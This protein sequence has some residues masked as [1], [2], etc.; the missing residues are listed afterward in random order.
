MGGATINMYRD[1]KNGYIFSQS[2]MTTLSSG[3]STFNNMFPSQMIP[4][5]TVALPMNYS[6]NNNNKILLQAGL[7]S[8]LIDANSTGAKSTH[9]GLVYPLKNP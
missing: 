5:I 1:E 4:N 2:T 6:S 8:I 7:S 9:F 3:T